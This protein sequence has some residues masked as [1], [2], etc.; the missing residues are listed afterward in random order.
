MQPFVCD[1]LLSPSFPSNTVFFPESTLT[2]SRAP[3]LQGY[4]LIMAQGYLLELL[5]M[6][7]KVSINLPQ[8]LES[9]WKRDYAD[10]LACGHV[11]EGL[12]I[13]VGDPP[14]MCVVPFLDW[15]YWAVSVRKA[16]WA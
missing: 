7:N 12:L 11:C 6:V 8:N 3:E 9:P 16:K 10:Q 14:W 13:L 1:N 5:L 15:T 4:L 2:P